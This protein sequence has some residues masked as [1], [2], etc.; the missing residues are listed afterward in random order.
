MGQRM[1]QAA[2]YL[3]ADEVKRRMNTE[4]RRHVRLHWWIVY[5]ALVAPRK[6]EEIALQTG[7]SASTVHRVISR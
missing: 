7:V 4:T 2:P 5:T 3:Q 1:T 6:A